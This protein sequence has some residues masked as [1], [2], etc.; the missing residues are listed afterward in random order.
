MQKIWFVIEGQKKIGPYSIMELR[1]LK[2]LTPDTL[3]WRRGFET[4]QPIRFVPELKEVF[5]DPE[6]LHPEAEE[7]RRRSAQKLAADE[8]VI[9]WG[10]PPPLFL[11]WLLL[12]AL[13]TAVLWQ[14]LG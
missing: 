2:G 5:E 10:G 3:V 9:D 13:L 6:P 14:L 7:W 12:L 8:I 4:P 11:L 1:G